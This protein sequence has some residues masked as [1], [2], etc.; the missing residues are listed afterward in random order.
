MCGIFGLWV[1][2]PL[3]K[4]DIK[5]A[6]D[7]T[8]ML[9]H[10]GPDGKGEYMDRENGLFLSHTRLSIIDLSDSNHQP[11]KKD[12]V[13]L[14]YNGEVY[15][16]KEIAK[17]LAENNIFSETNGDTEVVLNAWIK[18]GKKALDRFDGMFAFAIKDRDGLH[19][20]TDPFGEKPLYYVHR[21]DAVYFA[22]E[23]EPLIRLL[24]LS[25]EPSMDEKAA[26]MSLGYIPAP[27]TGFQDLRSM[28]PGHILTI[29]PDFKARHEHYWRSPES[30]VGKGAIQPLKQS[31]IDDIHHCLIESI[32]L[33]LRSDVPVGLFLSS[34]VDSALIASIIA[35]ELKQDVK[36]LTV[37]FRDGKDESV[38]AAAIADFLRLSHHT[39]HS[40]ED[41]E[42]KKTPEALLSLYGVP[43]DNMTALAVYQMS[44]LARQHFK[45]ALSGLG[46]DELFYGYQKHLF[47][48]QKGL[49]YRFGP[50]VLEV[51]R[52]FEKFLNKLKGWRLAHKLLQPTPELQYLSLKNNGLID[53][54]KGLIDSFEWMKSIFS[55]KNNFLAFDVRDFD[56]SY[57]LPNSHIPAIDRGSMRAGLEVRTPFLSRDLI[58]LTS[59]IDSRSF[60]KGGQKWVLRKILNCYLPDH[61]MIEGK[62]GFVYPAKRYLTQCGNEPPHIAGFNQKAVRS[63]WNN[64]VLPE[65]SSLAL[66]LPILEKAYEIY[67]P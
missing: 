58:T 55:G 59:Q 13:I 36:T 41:E 15:N 50:R 25:F 43:N 67:S 20:V 37:S 12:S 60:L 8:S 48:Y 10:R 7:A 1:N 30:L 64:R 27:K 34:G 2:R 26:F 42:W 45:V 66:R 4:D 63:I 6:Q 40:E 35:L 52:P 24:S 62:K 44:R 39:V 11:M 17:K 21:E 33:R 53:E 38:E 3:N 18:W 29:S 49:L 19:L 14:S 47:L 22:S 32:K 9:I 54:L 16:Y 61:L 56:L 57:S 65:F 46:G 28:P 51:L 31:Q 5:K 23:P